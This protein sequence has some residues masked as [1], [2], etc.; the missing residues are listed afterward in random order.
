MEGIYPKYKRPLERSIS[1]ISKRLDIEEDT[2]NSFYDFIEG[3][4]DINYHA[5]SLKHTSP[6]ELTDDLINSLL[7]KDLTPTQAII[8]SYLNAQGASDEEIEKAISDCNEGEEGEGK[9]EGEPREG[10]EEGDSDDK[11]GKEKKFYK[12]SKKPKKKHND[13]DEA[14][15]NTEESEIDPDLLAPSDWDND[16]ITQEELKKKIE[17][18]KIEVKAIKGIDVK[19]DTK[20][21]LD[22]DG[23]YNRSVR[24]ST[25]KEAY[26]CYEKDTRQEYI[27]LRALAQK[28]YYVTKSFNKVTKRKKY[29]VFLDNSSSMDSV[30]PMCK[31][32]AVLE[33]MLEQYKKGEID[34]VIVLFESAVDKVFWLDDKPKAGILN[35]FKSKYKRP[36]GGGTNIAN[37]IKAFREQKLPKKIAKDSAYSKYA[38]ADTIY[39]IVNDGADRITGKLDNKT[40]A[41][42]YFLNTSV[43]TACKESGGT[44]NVL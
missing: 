39:L 43:A 16:D 35:W 4:G 32:Y 30:E 8:T 5:D 40:H 15:D 20:W 14:T 9:E 27:A 31:T 26:E 33:H 24:V 13:K 38:D 36:P 19:G 3:K 2:L 7:H 17:Q 22:R 1:S 21:I 29:V 28:N 41:I 6:D 12:P 44:Y 42:G 25:M 11:D 23:A 18:F 10:K 34:L 37:A